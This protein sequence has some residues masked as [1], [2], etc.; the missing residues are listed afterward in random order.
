[1]KLHFACLG[2]LLA[3][4]CG[5]FGFPGDVLLRQSYF[6]APFKLAENVPLT[7]CSKFYVHVCG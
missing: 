2:E 3:L 7:S 5:I 6:Y 4:R 1:M